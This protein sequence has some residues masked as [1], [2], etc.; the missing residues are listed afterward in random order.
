[1]M[2]RILTT[3]LACMTVFSMLPISAS[4]A[5]ATKADFDISALSDKT[6]YEQNFDSLAEGAIDAEALGWDAVNSTATLEVKKGKNGNELIIRET[7]QEAQKSYF[8]FM[9][10]A[11]NVDTTKYTANSDDVTAKSYYVEYDLRFVEPSVMNTTSLV[12]NYNRDT[13]TYAQ[14]YFKC[15]TDASAFNFSKNSDL[16]YIAT[17]YDIATRFTYPGGVLEE[18][19]PLKYSPDVL[20]DILKTPPSYT[21]LADNTITVRVEVDNEA[22]VARVFVNDIYV[23]ATNPDYKP[24]NERWQKFLSPEGTEIAF[25]IHHDVKDATPPVIA[26][27]NIKVGSLNYPTVTFSDTGATMNTNRQGKLDSLPKAEKAGADFLGWYTADG[28]KVAEDF[29][30]YTDTTLTAKWSGEPETTKAPE[31]TKTPETTKASETTKA[32]VT[33][34]APAQTPATADSAIPMMVCAV[35]MLAV[36]A[37][38]KKSREN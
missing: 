25:R 34:A 37:A 32:P 10:N 1:M 22:Q 13:A 20:P 17:K 35:A 8:V 12:L 33:T 30:F 9:P 38:M 5:E 24:D 27:D 16:D 2:K 15:G 6:Y 29:T 4:A 3:T 36:M 21:L 7:A 26:I 28:V 19:A 31:T 23:T 11:K 14:L 18:R